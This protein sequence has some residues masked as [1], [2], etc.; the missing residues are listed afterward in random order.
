MPLLKTYLISSPWALRLEPADWQR[1]GKVLKDI[2]KA[3]FDEQMQSSDYHLEELIND[4][5]VLAMVLYSGN[6]PIGY[7]S[8]APLESESSSF[9]PETDP[10]E[11]WGE[12]DTFYADNISIIPEHRCADNLKFLLSEYFRLIKQKGYSRITAHLRK[13][14][15]LSLYAI[16]ILKCKRL[17][18]IRNWYDS[19]EDF[20]YVVMPKEQ[21]AS[22][23]KIP[24]WHD[25]MIAFRQRFYGSWLESLFRPS[26]GKTS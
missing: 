12:Y 7:I 14:N 5:E 19:G 20:D 21:V 6:K 1:H 8:G 23:E 16:R 2:E 9:D 17:K 22:Y 24:A 4:P 11:G 15:G 10:Q 18:T 26:T 13:S 3:C 25:A